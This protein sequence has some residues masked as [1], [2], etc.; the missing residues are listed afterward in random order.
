[1]QDD[2]TDGTRAM[3]DQKI[4]IPGRICIAGWSYGGYAA[5][6]GVIRTP[7]LYRCAVA[8]AAITDLD[9][10][11]RDR[12]Q[13][14][15]ESNNDPRIGSRWRDQDKMRDTSPVNNADAIS[16]PV[17]LIHGENDRI[18]PIEHSVLMDRQ[19]QREG[20]PHRFL[21]L[22][23]GDHVRSNPDNRLRYLKELEAFLDANLMQ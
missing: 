19:L 15:F 13:Y 16:V 10:L 3:I 2:I 11:L 8:G 9:K 21:R 4:A 18:V 1:M 17:L 5:L 20:V 23:G 6:M 22:A 14:L 12:G 7:N